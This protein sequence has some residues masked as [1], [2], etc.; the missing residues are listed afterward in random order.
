MKKNVR[1][2][3]LLLLGVFHVHAASS[4]E[5]DKPLELLF[6]G[7]SYFNFNDLP[8]MFQ[9]LTL[10][11]GHPVHV[12]EQITNGLFLADHAASASTEEKIN[13]RQ[14]DYVILQGSASRTAYPDY[15]KDKPALKAL[16]IL[17]NKILKNC[18][19]TKIVFCMPWA[20]EDGMTWVKGWTDDYT[21]MQLEI[22]NNTLIWAKKL[23][24]LIAPVGWAWNTVLEEKE[25]PLHY[26]HKS[27]W[28]HPT[29][30]GSYLTACVIYSTIFQSPVVYP[31]FSTL[32]EQDAKYYQ[33]IASNTV[34]DNLV[35]WNVVDFTDAIDETFQTPTRFKLYQNYPNPFN[36]NTLIHYT[37]SIPSNIKIEI[38]NASGQKV[39]ILAD[40]Y[41]EKGEYFESFNAGELA[42]G[43]YLCRTSGPNVQ[44]TIQMLYIK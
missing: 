2:F 21:D 17:K 25:F 41:H 22:Y 26:L 12:S 4:L 27:D 23:D 11:S 20:F 14:W 28:N 19:S 5:Q 38:I 42:T 3:L 36:H 34:L 10:F 29:V 8:H 37:I 18:D 32:D 39:A 13:S 1:I 6:I 33:E 7:S 15:Y 9:T 16:T 44:Q 24:I 30:R 43:T 35:L 40:R 31:W